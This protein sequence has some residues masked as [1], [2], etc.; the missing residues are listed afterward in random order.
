MFI[1]SPETGKVW[2]LAYHKEPKRPGWVSA[3]EYTVHAENHTAD[4]LQPT[5]VQWC[6]EIE[7]RATKAA[8]QAAVSRLLKR[9]QEIQPAE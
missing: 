8:R 4:L 1:K 9:I 5:G 3:T 7:G 2:N 6:S